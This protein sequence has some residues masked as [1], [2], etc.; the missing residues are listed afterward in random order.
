MRDAFYTLTAYNNIGHFEEM[1]KYFQYLTNIPMADDGRIQP[2][3]SINGKSKLVENELPLKSYMG[4]QPVRVGNDAHT[5]IQNDVYGQ[6]L[7]AILPLF[8]DKR[9]INQER[10]HSIRLV[11]TILDGIE[12]T[13]DEPDA[14]LWEFRNRAQYHAYSFLFQW[15]GAG[16]AAKIAETMGDNNMLNRATSL[17][18]RAKEYIEACYDDQR[19][20]YTQ[21]KG[22]KHLDASTLQLILMGYIDPSSQRAK[23]HLAIMEKELS[24]GKGLFYRYKH[25]DDFGEP[26]TTF[27]ICAYWYVETLAAVGR[28]DEAQEYFEHLYTYA[29]HVGLLSE[30]VEASTGSQWGNFPQAYS[31]VG[32]VNA[33]Y[34]IHKQLNKPSF[35]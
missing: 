27:M 5:H 24:A 31:H 17:M 6:I 4:N 15:A 35:M 32:L 14:G 20:V 1:E 3:W 21:A 29:N 22:V 26:E 2:L 12:Q 11:N 16:A 28:L 9:F 25:A 8:T 19:K 7:M 33:A 10:S 13:M 30:D 18:A 34:R 23:D